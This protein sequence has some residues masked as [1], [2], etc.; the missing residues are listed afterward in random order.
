M[1]SKIFLPET[2]EEKICDI[3]SSFCCVCRKMVIT[4]VWFIRKTQKLAKISDNGNHNIGP[5][6][7][8][9][10]PEMIELRACLALR[11]RNR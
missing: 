9:P 8:R 1:I 7:L 3:D 5:W 11:F 4:L 10:S 2:I 6:L